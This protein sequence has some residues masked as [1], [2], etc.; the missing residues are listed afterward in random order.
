MTT[1][2]KDKTISEA[3]TLFEQFHSIITTG[4]SNGDMGKLAVLA[5]VYKFPS[6]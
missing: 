4:K 1:L 2:I 3:E 6:E 5:G